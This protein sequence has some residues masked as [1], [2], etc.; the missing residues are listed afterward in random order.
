MFKKLLVPLDG[1]VLAEQALGVAGAIARAS[2]ANLDL[3]LVHQPLPLGAI[4]GQQ[5]AVAQWQAEDRYVEGIVEELK[6]SPGVPA[7]HT[8]LGGNVVDAIVSRAHDIDADLIVM[9]SH[10]RTGISRAWMGSVTDGVVRQARKPVLVLRAADSHVPRGTRLF[11]RIV[12]TLDGSALAADIVEPASD[13]ARC[14]WARLFLLRI[15]RPVPRIPAATDV[16]WATYSSLVP[17]E[18]ATRQLVEDAHQELAAVEH[19]LA[20][21]G[22]RDVE[23]HVVVDTHPA[24]AIIDFARAHE[25]DMIAMATHG[26]GASRLLLGSVAD[27]V[28]RASDLPVLL[29]R[30][31][32]IPAKADLLDAASVAE[33]LP[34]I[35]NI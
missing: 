16:T 18:V 2:E 17:D 22:L 7:S 24:Q 25:A 14:T 15:V 8:I 6:T 28:L 21:Q 31:L 20:L 9:T 3:V 13:L 30:P 29:R 34:A 26:R 1:S 35:A 10:G 12:V 4:R 23:T 11:N 5:R 32:V 27:K 33:Q 19:S